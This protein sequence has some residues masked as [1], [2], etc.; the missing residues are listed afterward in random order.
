MGGCAYIGPRTIITDRF[1]YSDA[2]GASWKQQT[3]LNIVK[4][5]NA[6]LPVFVDV[7]LVVSGYSLETN[8]SISGFHSPAD[9]D[10][11]TVTATVSTY[12]KGARRSHWQAVGPNPLSAVRSGDCW[13][14]VPAP[15][16]AT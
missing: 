1:N 8:L 3:L 5:R 7:S 9:P 14:Q 4:M 15:A 12:R 2:I 6:D 16:K 11:V 13:W 10:T